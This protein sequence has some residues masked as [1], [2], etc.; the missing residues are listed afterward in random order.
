MAGVLGR[1]FIQVFADLSKFTPGLRE[2]IKR[3]LDEQTKG[4]RFEELDKSARQAGESA[5]DEVAKGVDDKIEK[6]LKKEGE[7]GGKSFWSGLSGALSGIGAAFLP[8]LI[9]LG[10]ELVAG[11][12]PAVTA[13]AAT[14]PTAI[15]GAIAGAATLKL[16]F[17]GVGDALK[18]AFDPTKAAK[19]N[20]ALKKLAP[21][22]RSFVMEVKALQPVMHQIQQDVQQAFFVQLRGGLT[23]MARNLLPEVHR[24]LVVL[25]TDLGQLGRGIMNTLGSRQADISSIFIAAHEALRPLIPA[26]A[27]V[28][29]AFVTIAA[30]AGPLFASL[31]S[32]FAGLLTK[33]SQFIEASANSGA[34]AQFFD[35]ALV[36]LKQFGS[37][38]G[39][40]LRILGDIIGALQQTGAQGLGMLTGLLSRLEE[41]LRSAQGRAMLVALFQLLNTVLD[42][43]SKILSPLLPAV[44]QLVTLLAQGLTGA[45][46][47]LTPLL[48]AVTK[49][50]GQHP[51][52]LMAAA[53]A[54]AGYRLT[55]LAVAVAEGIVDA[56][57][58]AGL[59]ALAVAA[60]VAGI[61][62]IVLN[63]GKIEGALK[64]AWDAVVG[65][66]VGI[67]HWIESVGR[68]IGN[69]FTVTLPN[70]FLSLPGLIVAA[71]MSLPGLLWG[72]F[73]DALH[74]AGE[75]VGVGVGLILAYFIKMPGLVW[76][77]LVGIG[78]LLMSLWDL[79]FATAKGAL[80]AGIDATMDFFSKLPGRIE[81]FLSRLPGIIAGAF[82]SAF[83]WARR[84][85]VNGATA[86]V[87]FVSRLPGRISGFFDNVGH[88]IL[89]GLRAG[90]NSVI[91][92]FNSGIDSVASFIHIGLPHI[93][94]LA[95]GG[96][97]S[98][99]TLAVV[100][101]RGPEAVI[102]MGNP[103]QA[104]QAARQTGLLGMLGTAGGDGT[105]VVHVYLGT[106]E[107][108]DVL[109]VR[110][111]RKLDQQAQELAYGTR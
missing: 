84:E 4:I 51:A 94:M 96:L 31:S 3:S 56:L 30:V 15:A 1:A 108:T 18:S 76:D 67:W 2:E 46:V 13:L 27:Q 9:A 103:A 74:L 82:R 95:T 33:F 24:G 48:V 88:A 5:A 55:L 83:D 19:F 8:T 111:D 93:P 63:W 54:W 14:I 57:N 21:A 41:F 80:F 28:S 62:L 104:R 43:L 52:L 44:G 86:I 91:S 37:F 12:A 77:A 69:W 29:G 78:H 10:V 45:L 61:A 50:L 109:D 72:L 25:A 59:I 101:E 110:I 32:G 79:A 97:V 68:D 47:A 39:V 20:E 11:L 105:T 49:F 64:T 73:L 58:P 75:A 102:P 71:L 22:A 53:A 99:P 60:I 107:I 90:I 98:A 92:G 89:S 81:G 35:D 42:S 23:Q 100:G 38:L 40:V 70:F 17:H 65:F 26:L 66:F 34:M 7:K 16:A 36:V 85:V 87:D 106:K 6:D